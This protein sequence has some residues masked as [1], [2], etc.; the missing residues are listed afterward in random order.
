MSE[1]HS[2]RS[3]LNK[4]ND[5]ADREGWLRWRVRVIRTVTIILALGFPAGI[6]KAQGLAVVSP[7]AVATA[8]TDTN[9]VQAQASAH[10]GPETGLPSRDLE[11]HAGHVEIEGPL[12]QLRL[13]KGV[14][15]TVHRYRVTADRLNL[16]RTPQGI[17]VEGDGRVAFCPC[18]GPPLTVGFTRATVAPPTDLLLRNNTF[19]AC[20]VPV[21]WLPAFWVRSPNKL[22]LLT[23]QLAWRG[24]DGPWLSSGAHVPLSGKAGATSAAELLTGVYLKGGV[25]LGLQLRTSTS[26]TWLRWDHLAQSFWVLDSSGYSPK[27]EKVSLAWNVDTVLGARGK[28]GAISFERATRTHDRVRAE[29]SVADTNSL[30]ALGLQGDLRRASPLGESGDV[31]TSARWAVGTPLGD[32]G[33]VDSSTQFVG[34]M[35]GFE[36]PRI[37][38]QHASELGFDARPGP[39]SVRGTAHE[40]WLLGSGANRVFDAGLLGAE[41][42][43]GLP[44]VAQFGKNRSL[45]HWLEP[46]VMA[47][48]SLRGMGAAYQGRAVSPI[49]TLQMGLTNKVAPRGEPSAVSVQFRAGAIAEFGRVTHALASRWLASANWYALGGD[50]GWA[51]RDSWLSTARA[52]LGKLDRISLRSRLEGRGHTEPMA[53]RW[54]L[55]ESWSPWHLGW[56]SKAGWLL[57]ED[58]DLMLGYQVAVSGGVAY[59]VVREQFVSKRVSASYRHPCGCLA[60]SSVMGWRVGRSGWDA[61]IAFD[62]MP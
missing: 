15:L 51:G 42:R 38:A 41:L 16:E 18:E 9:A 37:V 53:V 26:K 44:L 21:F 4:E 3:A 31:G 52:R 6:A 33:R 17:V 25:D 13:S 34:R 50:I 59:D 58:I 48:A 12:K 36:Q 28:S 20:G 24:S 7:T 14:E 49:S 27:Q 62:L 22:G 32:F 57:S 47:N 56:L 19:R 39:L 43:V 60:I 29:L 54:L 23:P 46:F 5:G 10:S 30:Y 40:R 45:A 8:N 35:S 61:W 1:S 55:D 11:L 2:I